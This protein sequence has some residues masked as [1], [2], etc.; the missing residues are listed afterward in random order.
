[1][2]DI[3]YLEAYIAISQVKAQYCRAMDTKDWAGYG[4]DVTLPA[5]FDGVDRALLSDPQTSGGLLVA[6]AP[7]ALDAVLA[8]FAREGFGRAAVIGSVAD[9]PARLVI[10]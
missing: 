2:T 8:V 9:G 10:R 1:M 6:C 5:S 7:E 4:D 3:A